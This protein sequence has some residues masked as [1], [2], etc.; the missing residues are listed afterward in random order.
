MKRSEIEEQVRDA[1]D[2]L[3]DENVKAVP[4]G[5]DLATA[6][7]L[8]S[9]GRLELLAEVEDRFDLMFVDADVDSANTID[10]MVDAVLRELDRTKE[11]A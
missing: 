10:G 7:G 1:L 4:G 5:A 6:I 8:D 2:A 9:L 3:T 11:P